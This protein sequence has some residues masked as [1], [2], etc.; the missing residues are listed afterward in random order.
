MQFSQI[1]HFFHRIEDTYSDQQLMRDPLIT[2][3]PAAGS[4]FPNGSSRR[5]IAV[6]PYGLLRVG[7]DWC[8]VSPPR[9]DNMISHD[10]SLIDATH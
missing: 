5:L 1:T 9:S 2:L 3:F 4:P 6:M 8:C 7:H 10:Q